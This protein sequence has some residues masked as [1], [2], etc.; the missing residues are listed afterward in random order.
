MFNR[1]FKKTDESKS[2]SPNEKVKKVELAT[3]G[4]FFNLPVVV[5]DKPSPVHTEE[6]AKPNASMF[7]DVNVKP[8]VESASDG[9]LF[10]YRNM[11]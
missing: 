4:G 3:N 11:F 10:R 6:V 2:S 5:K 8:P 7:A 1:F 9:S